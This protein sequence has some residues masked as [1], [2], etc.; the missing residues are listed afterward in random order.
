MRFPLFL[1]KMI[2]NHF[3]IFVLLTA[4]VFYLTVL[5][6]LRLP[7]PSPDLG[8]A[9]FIF[10]HYLKPICIILILQICITIFIPKNSKNYESKKNYKE[11]IFLFMFFMLICFFHFSFK[12]WTP[13]V[14][15]NLFDTFYGKID[16]LLNMDVLVSLGKK[17]NVFDT[18]N[19]F[20]HYLFV[21][22]FFLSFIY[23]FLF[24]NNNNFRKVV[25][26]TALVLLI[27]ALCYW[28]APALGP[29][30]LQDQNSY[31]FIETFKPYQEHMFNLYKYLITYRDIP[32]GYFINPPA[33]MP[34][35]H[36]ANSLCLFFMM[37]RLSFF[38]S[39]FYAIFIGY[40][41]IIAIA[42]GWHYFIDLVFGA[43]LAFLCLKIVDKVYIQ[44]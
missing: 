32:P 33:A 16:V 43:L 8:S 6:A 10:R 35:L 3:E 42:S 40:L 36:I 34:S 27:G 9:T 29:F 7:I 28:I 5:C 17:L 12:I 11:I 25:I 23:H 44:R 31:K 1:K 41:V 39:V 21:S 26:G 18:A 19:I 37:K 22:L 14:N 4:L 38:I 30:Y 24:D 13:L 2:R 15:P 20:Y